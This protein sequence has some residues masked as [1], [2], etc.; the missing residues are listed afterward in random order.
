M[1][2][3]TA[4]YGNAQ[5]TILILALETKCFYSKKKTIHSFQGNLKGMLTRDEHSLN[6]KFVVIN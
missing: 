3:G 6:N 2:V 1:V 5:A 4:L